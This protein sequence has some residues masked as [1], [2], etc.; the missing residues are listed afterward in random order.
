MY[1]N[2]I[3]FLNSRLYNG[4]RCF[5]QNLFCLSIVFETA[6][7]YV[8]SLALSL[9]QPIYTCRSEPHK[10]NTNFFTKIYI[11]STVTNKRQP[12]LPIRRKSIPFLLHTFMSLPFYPYGL[13]IMWPIIRRA[14]KPCFTSSSVSTLWHG[15]S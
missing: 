14:W 10:K 1:K 11:A 9:F 15:E 7:K 5:N 8:K 13:L 3:L 6:S 4:E 12:A 2:C